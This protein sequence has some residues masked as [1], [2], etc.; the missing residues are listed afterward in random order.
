MYS[1]M[2]DEA[3]ILLNRHKSPLTSCC[4]FTVWVGIMVYR[5]CRANR[6]ESRRGNGTNAGTA[7]E[8]VIDIPLLIRLVAFTLFEIVIVV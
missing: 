2:L 7:P 1:A 4:N 8:S 5:N 6:K 3:G